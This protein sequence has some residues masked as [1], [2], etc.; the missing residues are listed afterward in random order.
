M[1]TRGAVVAVAAGAGG[2]LGQATALA[3]HAVVRTVVA[4][5]RR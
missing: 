5:D 4:V 2:G 1:I 3:I